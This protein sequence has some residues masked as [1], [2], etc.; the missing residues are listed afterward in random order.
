M[1]IVESLSMENIQTPV[2]LAPP[3]RERLIIYVR[4]VGK[5][6]ALAALQINVATLD[7]LMDGRAVRGVTAH[8]AQLV[9]D[10]VAPEKRAKRGAK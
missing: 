7:R 2:V 6:E 8:L 10:M 5:S 3:L 9:L 1:A 4:E